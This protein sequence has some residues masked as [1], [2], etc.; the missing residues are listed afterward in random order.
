M[1]CQL[2]PNPASQSNALRS[3]TSVGANCREACRARFRSEFVAKI[4]DCLKELEETTYQLELL[5]DSG[6]VASS[7]LAPLSQETDE[8]LAIFTALSEKAKARA[9]FT[10]H[11]S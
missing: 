3:G 11:P 7:K 6:K 4:G 10:L 9:S 5:G 8:L 2:C 1:L